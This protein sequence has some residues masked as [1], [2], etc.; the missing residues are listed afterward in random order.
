[1][2]APSLRNISLAVLNNE[3]LFLPI[4]GLPEIQFLFMAFFN[5]GRQA[6]QFFI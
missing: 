1:V 4:L 3:L 6:S 5:A 2:P